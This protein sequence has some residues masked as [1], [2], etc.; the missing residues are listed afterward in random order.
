M[1]LAC[2]P[3]IHVLI[4]GGCD[5]LFQEFLI[6]EGFWLCC[7]GQEKDTIFCLGCR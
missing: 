4:L 5:C 2:N 1:E 3:V 6:Y 7:L